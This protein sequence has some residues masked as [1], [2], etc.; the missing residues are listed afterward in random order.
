MSSPMRFTLRAKWMAI[1]GVAAFSFVL[2]I[3]A[4]AWIANRVEQQLTTIQARYLPK[5]ELE[6]RLEAQFERIQHG[7]QDAVASRDTETLAATAELKN[8]FLVFLAAA[9][10]AVDPADAQALIRALDLYYAA[11][12]SVSRRLIA[13]ETG[14]AMVDAIAAMQAEQTRFTE[15]LKKTTAFDRRELADAFARAVHAEAIAKTYRLWIT[16]A[17]LASVMLM[18]GWVSRGVLRSLTDLTAGFDRFGTGDFAQP[19]RS[20][21]RDEMGDLAERANQMAASLERSSREQRKAEERFRALLESAPDAMVIV[22]EDGR[23]ALVNARAESVFGYARSELLGCAVEVLVPERYRAKHP[24]HRAGYFRDPLVR[25][26]GSE[27]ELYGLRKDG[28]EFP[29][30]I[31]LSPL[32]TDEGTLVS[33]AIR[34]ITGRRQIEAALK[35]AN[36][37]LEAFSYSVAHDLRAPLRGIHGFSRALLE[38]Y[39]DKLDDEGRDF[40]DRIGAGAERMA[41]LI[42]ALLTLSRVSRVELQREAVNLSRAANAVVKHLRASQPERA[43]DFVNEQQVIGHGDAALLRALLENLLGNA[44]KFTGGRPSARIEFGCDETGGK[45]VYYVRDDGAGFDMAYADKLFAPFQRLH[46]AGAFAG[47][48]IGLA[49]V[50]RIVRRHG[51]KIWAE[52]AVGRGAT[53]YFTLGDPGRGAFS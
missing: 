5:L 20:A 32:R 51:G 35:L 42:D 21:G 33:S 46:D 18:S 50:Q 3:G 16:V 13:N 25:S 23:I 26:M 2:L 52:G 48:G 19:I 10:E 31:S 9:H 38:D 39:R 53:F 41:E 45:A 1:V 49:T 12:Y 8:T 36:G 6:P 22:G 27:L 29:I 43:V 11:A 30:E 44:W 7:F 17:C 14:E 40:L 47:T 37:E 4:S 15:V 34:D 24:G 28:T